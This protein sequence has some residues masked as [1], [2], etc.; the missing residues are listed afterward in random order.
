MIGLGVGGFVAGTLHLLLHAFF[1]ALLFL[2]SGSVIH[3]CNGV[4]DMRLKVAKVTAAQNDSARGPAPNGGKKA[5]RVIDFS[6]DPLI[7]VDSYQIKAVSA[8]AARAEAT[9]VFRRLANCDVTRKRTY[10]ADRNGRDAVTLSLE[11]DG[12][13]WW[14]QRSSGRSSRRR[15]RCASGSK[16][17][18]S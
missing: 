16:R 10:V 1:K 3:G 2:G 5:G 11:Y 8:G 4:Q 18:R 17:I 7:V 9:V 6:A 13:R 15:R 12:S 14:I